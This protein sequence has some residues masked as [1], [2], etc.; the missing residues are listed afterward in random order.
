MIDGLIQLD[1]AGT[2]VRHCRVIVLPFFTFVVMIVTFRALMNIGPFFRLDI[3]GQAGHMTTSSR[4]SFT[5]SQT[6]SQL[7][8]R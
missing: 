2:L 5:H 1:I 6:T 7:C 4:Y 8:Q 3:G